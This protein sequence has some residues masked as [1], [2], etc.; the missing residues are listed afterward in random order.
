MRQSGIYFVPRGERTRFAV[1]FFAFATRKVSRIAAL[2][3]EPLWWVPGLDVSPDGRSI[4][5]LR[6]DVNN[7]TIQLV[8][9]FR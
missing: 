9:N 3:Q 1:C 4:L 7:S 2:E 8:E 6:A 5:Y